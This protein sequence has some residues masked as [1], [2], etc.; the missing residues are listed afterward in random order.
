MKCTLHSKIKFIAVFLTVFCCQPAMAQ[1]LLQNGTFDNTTTD[2]ITSCTSIEATNP[3]T[4]YG[5]TDPNNHVAEVDDESCFHQDIC[6]LPGASYV[7][8]MDA[9]CR[10]AGGPNPVTMH[11]NITGLD[12]SNNIIA[13]YVDMD[14][15]ETNTVFAL[16]PV[17]GIPVFAVPLGPVVRVR[18]TLTDNTPGYSTYGTI[19]D[20]LSLTFATPPAIVSADTVCLNVID[21][22]SIA[23][24]GASGITY[25]WTF[26]GQA[27]IATSTAANPDVSWA[28]MGNQ[29]VTC[30]L[31]NGTCPVD[32]ATVNVYVGNDPVAPAVTSP[33]QYCSG[34]AAQQL[35]ATGTNLL[36]YT[37]ATGG[38]GDPTAPTPS[39][40]AAGTTS[41]YVSQGHGSCESP[42]S[43]IIVQVYDGAHADFSYQVDYGCGKDTVLFTNLSTGG[44]DYKWDFNDG[45]VSID[46][47]PTHVYTIQNVFNV[48]LR[49]TNAFCRDSITEAIDLN[50]PLSASFTIDHDT[51]C[52]GQAVTFT[53]TSQATALGSVAPVYFWNFGDGTT[54]TTASPSHTYAQA[55]IYHVKMGV[56]DFV[57]CSDTATLTVYVDSTSFINLVLNPDFVCQGKKFTFN[58][59]YQHDGNTGIYWDFGDGSS[60]SGEGVVSHAYENAGTYTVNVSAT[61]LICPEVSAS[62]Q[63]TV[64]AYPH[65]NLGPDTSMCPN[66]GPIRITDM[67][68]NG[69]SNAHWL[70]NT[71]DTV[72]S[73]IVTGPGLYYT[74]VTLN[75]CTGAD[76]VD[77][78]KDCYIDVPNSFTPNGD[79]VNDYFFPRQFLSRSVT[80]FAM[81]VYNRWGQLIFTTNN[82]SGRGWDGKFNNDIQPDGVYIYVI[83]VSFADGVAEHYQGNVT[84]LR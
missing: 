49:T 32:T 5:G 20:N 42:R 10:T 8:S 61:Y 26:P 24:V 39:T 35:T 56:T 47:N 45:G 36:W 75:G 48:K 16:N 17:P 13:T 11:I 33:I 83:D 25:N 50:H 15:T 52:L 34:T 27:S 55:G 18:V 59:D 66:A 1:N 38:I 57:P 79:G 51:V 74:T 28:S 31:G 72:A 70:W 19:V 4:T 41:Y 78:W 3:E 77:V 14:H 54:D 84:L 43:L 2:W 53:N 12:A 6:V 73:I 63:L 30:A 60:I 40:A 65:V 64:A 58:A 67:A 29:A 62:Q 69:N 82:T 44:T 9:S 76:S 68:N 22:L 37:A 81:N 80:T 23:N 71:G 21:H 7:Y 46:Q